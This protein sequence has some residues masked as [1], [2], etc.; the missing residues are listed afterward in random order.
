[1]N[2]SLHSL[3][4]EV[5]MITSC[6]KVSLWRGGNRTLDVPDQR[7]VP[8]GSMWHTG[9]TGKQLIPARS[10]CRT[11]YYLANQDKCWKALSVMSDLFHDEQGRSLDP[12]T[13]Q[14]KVK[15]GVWGAGEEAEKRYCAFFLFFSKCDELFSPLSVLNSG[16]VKITFALNNC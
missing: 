12:Q 8:Q 13:L 10:H 1:M 2:G 5:S 11:S 15:G 14:V 6:G 16:S 4:W 9:R 7:K 3:S